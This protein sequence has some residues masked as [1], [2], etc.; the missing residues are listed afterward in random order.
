MTHAPAIIKVILGDNSSQR[1]NFQNGLPD[2]VSELVTEV[3]RQCGINTNFRLQ[4]MD[5]LFGNEF[6]NL[7]SVNEIQDRGTVKLIPITQ[8]SAPQCADI[9]STS[10]TAL[11]NPSVDETS[12]MSSVCVDTDTLSTTV[13][14]TSSSRQFWPTFFHV[15]QFSFDAELKLERGNAAYKEKGTFLIPDPK[16]KSNILEGLV[17]EI[18]K[19][20]V[21]ATDKEFNIVGEAL[22]SKHPCLTEKGSLTGYAGWKASLKNKL[23]IYRTHLRKLGCPEVLVNSVKHKPADKANAAAAI[24]K[25][26]RSEVNYCPPHPTGESDESLENLRVA[27]LSEVKK[28][29]NREVIRMKMEKTFSHRRYEVVRDTPMIQDFKARW[30]AL[31]DV[32]QKRGGQ[33]GRRLQSIMEPMAQ[34]DDVDVGR[35]CIIK[36]LCVYLNEDL[37][38]LVKEYVY[39]RR[40]SWSW[41][42]ARYQ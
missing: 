17:Q 2:S 6:L 38:N 14:E 39:F 26:R 1:L 7:T 10:E 40:S 36:G 32:F 33:I 25:P 24:K 9:P 8:A 27:L 37:G 34:D 4:F 18:V 41:K 29:N 16:L 3:Q 23:A 15:P 30:P 31:F 21:Y 19:Y 20:K 35:E 42:A 28:N 13:F 5:A 12:S 22:I 11:C